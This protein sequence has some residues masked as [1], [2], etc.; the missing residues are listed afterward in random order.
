MPGNYGR[1]SVKV[2][3]DL[4]G[5]R[6]QLKAE[7][8][9]IDTKL[10]V[11]VNVDLDK[12]AATTQLDA[13]R[14]QQSRKSIK[15]DIDVDSGKTQKALLGFADSVLGIASSAARASLGLTAMVGAA[16][17]VATIA[18][19]LASTAGALLLI[20][21]AAGVAASAL[22][23]VK[24]GAAGIKKAFS[25]LTPTLN[26]LKR[27]VSQSFEQSLNPAVDHLKHVLPQ[28]TTG[29]KEN[30]TA[31]GGI[32]TKM[33]AWIDS[34]AGIKAVNTILGESSRTIQNVGKFIVPVVAGLINIGAIGAPILRQLTAGA[35]QAGQKFLEWTQSAKGIQQIQ[36]WIE[37]GINALRR[38]WTVGSTV[39]DI[40]RQIV[41]AFQA[42]GIG[43][44]GIFGSATLELD[45]FL[46]TAEGKGALDA[47]AQTMKTVADVVRKVLVAAFQQLGP[48]L[49]AA[50][51]AIREIA[52][53][54]GDKLVS[55]INTVGPIIRGFFQFLSDHKW[56]ADLAADLIA[57]A[58][59]L[60][61]I[62]SAGKLA[63]SGISLFAGTA[64]TAGKAGTDAG[65]SFASGLSRAVSTGLNATLIAV[66]LVNFISDVTGLNAALV[67]K[68]G[69]KISNVWEA[70]WQLWFGGDALTGI[71]P[72]LRRQIT[73][74]ADRMTEIA[75][76]KDGG[77]LF[78]H[79][80]DGMAVA[81][82]EA[83]SLGAAFGA[84][85]T[86]LQQSAWTFGNVANSIAGGVGSVAT[87]LGNFWG[88][89]VNA[90]NASV[91]SMALAVSGGVGSMA[92]SVSNGMGV[93]TGAV[94]AGMGNVAGVTAANIGSAVGSVTGGIGSM[95]G[96]V[97]GGMSAIQGS[98][99]GG[100]GS[101]L[102]AV[103]GNMGSAVG[104]VG[105][106][107]GFITGAVGSA[108]GFVAG[109]GAAGGNGFA[110]GL[111]G[112]GGRA[113]GGMA[114]IAAGI[115][116]AASVDLSGV[117]SAIAQGLANGI[118]A[119]AGAAVA[120]AAAMASRVGAAAAAA[121]GVHSP[122]KMMFDQGVWYGPGLA[123]GIE[124]N[125]DQAVAA[126]TA[127]TADVLDAASGLG[128]MASQTYQ[129]AVTSATATQVAYKV[130]GD[131]LEDKVATALSG[132]TVQQ[133]AQGTFRL[134]RQAAAKNAIG[135]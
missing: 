27:A 63:Q 91:G 68:S 117:G 121:A 66:P 95:V 71:F 44:G 87:S 116:G 23:A 51:P 58:G 30:A 10:T 11:Q 36:G 133:D 88:Q 79:V 29:F 19:V 17:G 38:L 85:A 20:P 15:Q 49:Q 48:I 46:H 43:I 39:V 6:R 135:R 64:K 4:T 98:S 56:A 104:S 7:L 53:Q 126:A 3:P 37:G 81:E 134:N 77:G 22:G 103:S 35:G 132:W 99:A 114:G 130:S 97:F 16:N 100:M 8:E 65:G 74:F 96:S 129:A 33:A 5:F 72:Q 60:K 123:L 108:M 107:M 125:A 2:T 50:A 62:G 83:G 61:L 9:A 109:Q 69:G 40:V 52:T 122:S 127:M 120:A 73:D 78:T 113:V 12:T 55:A 118:N 124:K 75:T 34:K 94:G 106:S 67:K 90:T 41:G 105:R 14:A 13:W 112:A 84:S 47:L 21:A 80:V 32:A 115:R 28:L 89:A 26:D 24:L 42:N 70:N 18:P 1:A 45:K 31:I 131:S 76:G 59:A 119:R 102:A 101:F 86:Q 82:R 25:G 57:V 54:L 92:A 111:I 93:I 110:N 128:S